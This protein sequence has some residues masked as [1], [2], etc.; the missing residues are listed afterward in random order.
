MHV[1]EEVNS[2]LQQN[3]VMEVI[4]MKR[5]VTILAAILLM[6]GILSAQSTSK[7]PAGWE[8][9]FSDDFEGA[10][11]YPN[12]NRVEKLGGYGWDQCTYN[13]YA[14]T[15]SLWC[16]GHNFGA[17]P[18]LYP[19]T[20]NYPNNVDTWVIWTGQLDA[21]YCDNIEISFNILYQTQKDSD[22]VEF[23]AN[24]GDPNWQG[25]RFSGD[26]GGWQEM[27]FSLKNWP[28]HGNMMGHQNVFFAYRF[29]SSSSIGYK[30]VFIDNFIIRKYVSGQPDLICSAVSFSPQSQPKGGLITI[31]ATVENIGNYAAGPHSVHYVLSSDTVMSSTDDI[32]TAQSQL[33][34]KSP[35]A[36]QSFEKFCLIP[37]TI[38]DGEYYVGVIVDPDNTVD[39]SNE[40]NNTAWV[41]EP[42]LIGQAAVD[43]N[44]D[45]MPDEFKLYQNY[46]NPFNPVTVI[47]YQLPR[48]VQVSLKV[49][50]LMG[51][52]IA[53]LI[54]EIQPP[55][56]YSAKWQPGQEAT[57]GI[58]F[59]KLQAG[60]FTEIKKM[61]LMK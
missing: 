32:L 29:F 57:N 26:S 58:Y 21:R 47:D 17:N 60:E 14:G 44:S 61:T 55:G 23:L 30:G 2:Y 25:Y 6:A 40:T 54:D 5:V 7:S 24:Y 28:V 3:L 42:L 34:G 8:V 15:Y 51:Q 11:P 38:A 52:E 10:F 46:P 41:A 4:K 56:F 31:N 53:V 39:E 1:L 49:Y 45:L 27:R 59:Y 43:L 36:T 18:Q 16:V 20:S 22:Y 12:W 35:G 37:T 33:S 19:E 9:V 48:P 50:N 13:P